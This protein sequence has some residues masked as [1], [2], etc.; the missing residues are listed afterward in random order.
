[1]TTKS[2]SKSAA[3]EAL[4][5]PLSY[6][7]VLV[8]FGILLAA[9]LILNIIIFYQLQDTPTNDSMNLL[10]GS[11][12]R[13]Q[14]SDTGKEVVNGKM[15]IR[16]DDPVFDA[17]FLTDVN[18]KSCVNLSAMETSFESAFPTARIRRVDIN[19]TNG[20]NLV[21][22]GVG[23]VPAIILPKEVEKV[24]TFPQFNQGGFVT[25]I[26][27]DWYEFRTIG[28]KKVLSKTQLPPASEETD[29]KLNIVGYTNPFAE[30]TISFLT[31]VRQMAEQAGA[32]FSWK[33]FVN[34][35]PTSFAAEAILC[36]ADPA[37]IVAIAQ[38]YSDK[39]TEITA[40]VSEL[41]QENTDQMKSALG[42]L[43]ALRDDVK[44]CYDENQSAETV[45]RLAAE[46]QALGIAGAPA[47]FVGDLFLAGQQSQE[48][49]SQ[50]ISEQ[51][52]RQDISQ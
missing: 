30:D 20:K 3:M 45:Q 36:G 27:E 49:F 46:A 26:S 47:Y 22:Q 11:N 24:S 42:E 25:P 21:S 40:G 6:S 10:S 31:V 5:K 34:N 44:T 17:Y 39:V 12:S 51:M 35:I 37:S 33:P 41:T 43:L 18:C 29:G 28:N 23:V 16:L 50:V 14:G 8:F 4:N 13:L 7:V 38:E 52:G 32:A 48:T 9:S 15:W 19:S 2:S 1:M